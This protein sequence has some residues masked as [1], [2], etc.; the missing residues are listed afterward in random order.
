MF[1]IGA[2]ARDAVAMSAADRKAVAQYL[3]GLR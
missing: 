1:Q 3:A 2:R